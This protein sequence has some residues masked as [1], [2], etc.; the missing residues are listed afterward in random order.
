MSY[1]NKD[2]KYNLNESNNSEVVIEETKSY[3]KKRKPRALKKK[4]IP[5]NA[6]S[7]MRFR[8]NFMNRHPELMRGKSKVERTDIIKKVWGKKFEKPTENMTPYILFRIKYINDHRVEMKKMNKNKKTSIIKS[9]WKSISIYQK[10]KLG[11]ICKNYDE[12]KSLSEKEKTEMIKTAWKI[13]PEKEKIKVLKKKILYKNEKEKGKKLFEKEKILFEKE[14]KQK[15]WLQKL[16]RNKVPLPEDEK[17][18]DYTIFRYGYMNI[19]RTI[20]EN[21]NNI[22]RTRIIKIEWSKQKRKEEIRA[23]ARIKK[24]KRKDI[25]N[26]EAKKNKKKKIINEIKAVGEYAKGE[27]TPYQIFCSGYSSLYGLDLMKKHEA[28]KT[29]QAWK[30]YNESFLNNI[31]KKIKHEK[32]LKKKD[33]KKDKY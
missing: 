13:S 10:F 25:V 6:S 33:Y 3:I 19:N 32:A 2:I 21:I 9:A 4:I 29:R 11:F 26:S 15:S 1:K 31:R 23:I 18:S 16:G 28:D 27:I 7:Y 30:E 22:E 20:F 5:E 17:V 24:R 14:K 8:L 12:L